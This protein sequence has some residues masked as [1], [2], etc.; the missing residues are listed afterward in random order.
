MSRS[1]IFQGLFNGIIVKVTYLQH[2]LVIN[3][4]EDRAIDLIGL[5]GSPVEHGQAELGLDGLL[6]SNSCS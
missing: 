3:V 5:Q 6:D 1:D 4:T 2:S